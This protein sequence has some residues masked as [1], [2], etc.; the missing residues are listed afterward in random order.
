VSPEEYVSKAAERMR[1]DGST[2]SWVELGRF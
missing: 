2:V 1:T